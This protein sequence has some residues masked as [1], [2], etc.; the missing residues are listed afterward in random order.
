LIFNKSSNKFII[1]SSI[2]NYIALINE[3]D[4]KYFIYYYDFK[5]I[6]YNLYNFAIQPSYL[7]GHINKYLNNYPIKERPAINSRLIELFEPISYSDL[8]YSLIL[9]NKFIAKKSSFFIFF[10]LFINICFKYKLYDLIT[11]S[12][13]NIKHSIRLNH[14]N[15][16]IKDLYNKIQN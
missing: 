11:S 13:Q 4:L 10:N 3:S 5:L 6:L 9:I 12:E 1:D 16:S 8:N 7:K 2:E 15:V 14:P